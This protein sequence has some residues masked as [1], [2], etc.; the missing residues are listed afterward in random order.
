MSKLLTSLVFL[1]F[2]FAA[3]GFAVLAVWDV[4]VAQMTVEKTLDS[5]AFLNRNI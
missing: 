3:G 5:S 4:P 2:V 1:A